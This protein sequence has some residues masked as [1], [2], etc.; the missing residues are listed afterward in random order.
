[1]FFIRNEYKD[2]FLES[3]IFCQKNKGMPI[4]AWCII[5]SHVHLIFN[6]T[7]EAEPKNI[8]GDLKRFTS[9]AIVKAIHENPKE[10]RKEFLL[11]YIKKE[12]EKS[13]NVKHFNFGGMII[14]QLNYRAMKLF[15][16]KWII[17]TIILL[18]LV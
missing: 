15:N 16:K 8:L 1:M 12:A 7:T 18:K 17:F 9:Q 10:I 6:S 13:S 5:S 2:L 4:H 14:N 11:D 3:L